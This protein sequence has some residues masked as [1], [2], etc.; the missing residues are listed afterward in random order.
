MR[1]STRSRGP[2][3]LITSYYAVV[4]GIAWWARQQ[5]GWASILPF[6]GIDHL[7]DAGADSFEVV[8]SVVEA[9]IME[10]FDSTRLALAIFTL[11]DDAAEPI[12]AMIISKLMHGH[13]H[14][15]V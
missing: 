13:L 14:M 10:G 15:C 2:L 3:F 6:G 8:T 4:L 5:P 11:R 1:R 12:V 7:A 9:G